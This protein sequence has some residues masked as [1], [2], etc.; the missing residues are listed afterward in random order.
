MK[1]R[2]RLANAWNAFNNSK[3]FRPDVTA[4]SSIFRPDR[5]RMGYQTEKTIIGP[6]YNRI[7]MDISSAKIM[8][9]VLDDNDRYLR[10]VNSELNNCLTLEANKDQTSNQ[11]LQDVC[12]SLFDEGVVA[13]VPVD[14]DISILDNSRFKVKTLRTGK[15]LEW[16]PDHV[17]VNVYN[18][19]RGQREDLILPKSAVAI[20]EN[21]LYAVMNE[22]NGTLKRL[23]RKLALIDVVDEQV[24][25]GKLDVIIQLPYVIKTQARRDEA[26]KRRKEIEMQLTDSK[27]GIAYTDGTEK[28]VQLNRPVEN[29]LMTQIEFLTTLLYS[30]LGISKEVLEGTASEEQ[31]LNYYVR[32]LEPILTAITKEMKRKFLSKTARTQKQS[33]EFFRDSFKLVPVTK[34]AEIVDSF[35]RNEI[36]SSNE[37]RSIMGLKP[38]EQPRA[39]ELVNKNITPPSDE[40]ANQNEGESET[41]AVDAQLQE[42]M[43]ELGIE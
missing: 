11:F 4:Y 21:P 7:S 25:S 40:T 6:I 17:R 42:L 29:N 16:F 12:I 38:S 23:M 22:P 20:I 1:M 24:S 9:V 28:I 19:R 43:K 8:H 27:Y 13:I 14:T 2:E 32:T 34:L 41:D 37:V 10:T 3:S 36:M 31:M 33:I 30:Q 35:T 39:E 26:E 18:D 15:I 5:A